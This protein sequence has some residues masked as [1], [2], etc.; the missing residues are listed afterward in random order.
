MTLS[1]CQ[2]GPEEY[3]FH[4]FFKIYHC[5]FC[6]CL[7]KH[8]VSLTACFNCFAKLHRVNT[9]L[10]SVGLFQSKIFQMSPVFRKSFLFILKTTRIRNNLC[11]YRLISPLVVQHLAKYKSFF[12]LGTVSQPCSPVRQTFCKRASFVPVIMLK[13][14]YN[15]IFVIVLYSNLRNVH[16]VIK[17]QM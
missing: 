9:C 16:I 8:V 6:T 3:I 12:V 11:I 14:H 15:V 10:C 5:L 7:V 4:F 2:K 13:H 17:S 1:Y